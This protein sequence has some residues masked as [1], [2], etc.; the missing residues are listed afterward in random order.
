MWN[1]DDTLDSSWPVFIWQVLPSGLLIDLKN[2]GNFTSE[3][4][5]EV[6]ALVAEL[7]NADLS[8]DVGYVDTMTGQ[9]V[10]LKTIFSSTIADPPFPGYSETTWPSNPDPGE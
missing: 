2:D 6:Y 4:L 1:E 8:A 5:D 3:Q 10:I 9:D 7:K